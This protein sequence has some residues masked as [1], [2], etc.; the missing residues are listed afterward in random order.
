MAILHLPGREAEKAA[1]RSQ[2]I[3]LATEPQPLVISIAH[4]ELRGAKYPLAISRYLG[5][6]IMKTE[7]RLDGLLG[8]RLSDLLKI[9]LYPGPRGTF[10]IIHAPDCLPPG[11]LVVGLGDVGEIK[12]SVVATGVTNAALRHALAVFHRERVHRRGAPARELKVTEAGASRSWSSAAFSSLLLGTYGR[13]ALSIEDSVLAIIQGA[14]QANKILQAQGLY[15]YVRIHEVELI[16]FYEDLA[17]QAWSAASKFEKTPPPGLAEVNTLKVEPLKLYRLSGGL[18]PR[19]FDA[20]TNKSW[21]RI[22]V[23]RSEE[24]AGDGLHYLVLT[25]RARAEDTLQFTQRKV[26][27]K[28]VQSSAASPSFSGE[29]VTML[30]SLLIPGAIKEHFISE[31]DLI[32]VLDQT[33]AQYPWELLAERTPSNEVTPFSVRMGMIRQFK[34]ARFTASPH[35]TRAETALVVGVPK[36][37]ERDLPAARNEAIKVAAM[38]R[39]AGYDVPGGALIDAESMLVFKR[40]FNREYK[41]LHLAGH[42]QYV[43]GKPDESGIILS[44]GMYLSSKE[45]RN[46][47]PVPELVFINCCYL[48]R[49][50]DGEPCLTTNAPYAL[51]ASIAEELINMGVKAVVAAGWAVDDKAAAAFAERFYTEMLDGVQ[52]GTAVLRA[53]IAAKDASS[54]SNTWG[55]YQ[56]YG[57]PDFVLKPTRPSYSRREALERL[58]EI[59]SDAA[60][61]DADGREELRSQLEDLSS[62]VS[63]DPSMLRALGNVWDVLGYFDRAVKSYRDALAQDEKAETPLSVIE[64]LATALVHLADDLRAQQSKG[65]PKGA[66]A[67]GPTQL[68]NEAIDYL[69]ALL[70]LGGATAERLSLLGG[71]YKRKAA[72]AGTAKEALEWLKQAKDWYAKAHTFSKEKTGTVNPYPALNWLTSRFLLG[73]VLGSDVAVINDSVEA[74][75][76]AEQSEPSFWNKVTE[77]DAELLRHLLGGDVDQHLDDVVKCY[78][79]AFGTHVTRRQ[80]AAVFNHFDFLTQMLSTIEPKKSDT[81]KN[82]DALKELRAKIENGANPLPTSS[83]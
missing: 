29:L 35:T 70:K 36:S 80:L 32:L 15:D 27:E 8:G 47:S 37:R 14:V 69:E 61:A 77:A 58:A 46:L 50:D 74:A 45:L 30:F 5:D 26:I 79:A 59:E 23:T 44:D 25:D 39:S 51:A 7:R 73:E 55:A 19:P 54:Q 10:E 4:G 83:D 43:P 66:T 42:G 31:T 71:A 68:V 53:R 48:G 3:R 38:L 65:V 18:A 9:F 72:S 57:H 78:Q 2:A 28:A 60:G 75:K 40:L 56:C 34:T 12:N 16:E 52:F 6:T 1:T 81:D 82:I 33:S 67:A 64:R 17:R 21:G 62:A 24:S 63:R 76:K 41:I 11:A 13:N 49:I 20:P 22:Q